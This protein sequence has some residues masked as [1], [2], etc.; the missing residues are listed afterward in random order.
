MS[1]D[2]LPVVEGPDYLSFWIVMQ[3]F[4]G[5]TPRRETVLA[6]RAYLIRQVSES[7]TLLKRFC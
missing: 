6:R 2:S 5:G 4:R 3:K 1:T 7:E